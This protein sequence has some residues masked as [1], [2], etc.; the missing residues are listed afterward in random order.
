MGKLGRLLLRSVMAV[1]FGPMEPSM[2]VM[3]Q[4]L[5]EQVGTECTEEVVEASH[6]Y[7][8]YTL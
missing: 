7:Y 1:L 2:S 3:H 4:S 8:V 6:R 5:P